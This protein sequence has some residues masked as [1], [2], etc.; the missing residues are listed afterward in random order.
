MRLT[1]ERFVKAI[2]EKGLKVTPQRLAVIDVLV[3]KGHLHPGANLVYEEAGKKARGLSLSTV[4]ATLSEFSRLGLIRTME[5]D[6]MENR[7]EGNLEDHVN[8]VCEKCGSIADYAMP[9][10]LDPSEVTQRTGFLV[11]ETRM[12]CY[13]YCPDC[14]KDRRGRG[15][16][17]NGR[18]QTA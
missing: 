5:Y 17:G 2:R 14:L 1:K 11:T 18:L 6:R 10:S 16:R 9:A 7:Y 8:L 3:E 15:A 12:E 4:Y 13:G